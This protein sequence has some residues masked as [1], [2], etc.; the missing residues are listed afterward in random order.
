MSY[1]VSTGAVD[2][3]DS[4]ACEDIWM[5]GGMAPNTIGARARASSLVTPNAA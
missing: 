5:L 4:I 3:I 1:S 2:R